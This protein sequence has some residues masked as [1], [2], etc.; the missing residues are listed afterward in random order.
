M[1]VF[2]RCTKASVHAIDSRFTVSSGLKAYSK[3]SWVRKKEAPHLTNP[4][5]R[6]IVWHIDLKCLIGKME[7]NWSSTI[8]KVTKWKPLSWLIRVYLNDWGNKEEKFC[9]GKGFAHTLSLATREGQDPFV[10]SSK[11]ACAWV[12]K[13]IR[14]KLCRVGKNVWVK[15]DTMMIVRDLCR[16]KRTDKNSMTTSWQ[17]DYLIY[18]A[19]WVPFGMKW[20]AIVVSSIAKCG[21]LNT[22][23]GLYLKVSSRKERTWGHLDLSCSC[24][25]LASA[26]AAKTSS[27]SFLCRLLST[28]KYNT[29]H[30]IVVVVVSVPATNKSMAVPNSWRWPCWPWKVLEGSPAF[31]SV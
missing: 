7:L 13:S 3:R 15:M 9:P 28:A 25:A 17:G 16:S 14:Q 27:L 6:L 19:T 24:G 12:Y 8:L 23:I 2:F 30:S 31:F 22:I 21:A 29:A 11:S 1:K 20:P 10:R 26:P 5:N 4:R 18:S